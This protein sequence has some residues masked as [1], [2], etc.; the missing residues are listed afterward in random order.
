[1]RLLGIYVTFLSTGES[2]NINLSLFFFNALS[3]KIFRK[4][5]I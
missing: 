3:L 5:S 1:M 2:D 4:C